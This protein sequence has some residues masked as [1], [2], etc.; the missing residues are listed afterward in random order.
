M[1]ALDKYAIHN[2]SHEVKPGSRQC[3]A[4]NKGPRSKE[5][6]NR[7]MREETNIEVVTSAQASWGR[8]TARVL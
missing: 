4:M 3:K 2:T 8:I 5:S 7:C 1:C 6:N